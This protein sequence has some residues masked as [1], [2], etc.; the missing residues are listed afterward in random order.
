MLPKDLARDPELAAIEILDAVLD[1]TIRALIAAH[2]ELAHDHSHRLPPQPSCHVAS[3]IVVC[4][5]ELRDRLADYRSAIDAEHS[6]PV[7]ADDFPF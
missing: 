6:R 4:A 1:A 3:F 2:P 5:T 7:T